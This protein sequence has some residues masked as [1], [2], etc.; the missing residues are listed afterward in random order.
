MYFLNKALYWNKQWTKTDGKFIKLMYW[1]RISR[2]KF[3][4]LYSG[5]L[6]NSVFFSIRAHKLESMSQYGICQSE[7]RKC[8]TFWHSNR[9]NSKQLSRPDI[10]LITH[11]GMFVP[12]NFKILYLFFWLKSLMFVSLEIYKSLQD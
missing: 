9:K 5:Y 4:L 8:V 11:E 2:H 1:G 6:I 7:T 3:V 12:V 10:I